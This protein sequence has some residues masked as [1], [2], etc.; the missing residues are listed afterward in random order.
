MLIGYDGRFITEKTTGNGIYATRLIEALSMVDDHNQY[1]LYWA[2]QDP[3]V[4]LEL[5]KNVEIQIMYPL[6]RSAWVRVPILFPWEL[7]R[8][9]V[10]IF[11]AHYTVPAWIWKG[12]DLFG[13]ITKA[14]LEDRVV[15]TGYVPDEDIS[16][17]YQ[18]AEVFCY[19]S[20]YEGFGFPILEAMASGVP[21][22]VS[23]TSSCP[24]VGGPAVL[25][26]ERT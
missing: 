4:T 24:E 5:R 17:L 1:R 6:H 22:V 16:A 14:G 12:G 8:R 15:T 11:H 2:D 23:Q 20:L 9:S 25:Y 10:D 13:Q 21:V 7:H 26:S 19:P 3:K 18:G